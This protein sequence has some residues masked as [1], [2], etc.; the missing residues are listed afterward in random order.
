MTPKIKKILLISGGAVAVISLLVVL[1]FVFNSNGKKTSTITA[2]SATNSPPSATSSNTLAEVTEITV[3]SPTIIQ[4]N[5]T[6]VI[7]NGLGS[8][9]SA[10]LIA[11]IRSALTNSTGNLPHSIRI[12][13]PVLR[14]TVNGNNLR[15]DQRIRLNLADGT[16]TGDSRVLYEMPVPM[17]KTNTDNWY[18]QTIYYEMGGKQIPMPPR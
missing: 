10:A 11:A 2:D 17:L 13:A 6:T 7:T 16:A 3:E 8:A 9:D 12:V 14:Q 5:G 18:S 15:V 1:F 4:D